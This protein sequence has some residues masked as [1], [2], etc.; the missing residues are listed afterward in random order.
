M[1]GNNSTGA[2][3]PRPEPAELVE[4][5]RRARLRAYC[6][7]SEFA[8]GAAVL[9]GPPWQVTTGCNIENAAYSETVC[10]ERVAVYNA[11]SAALRPIVAIAVVAA[12]VSPPRPC[13]ACLQ[14]LAELAPGADLYLATPDGSFEQMGL[15]ELLP[16][17]FHL[18][19]AG[20]RM[21]P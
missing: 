17:P 12:G 10:A 18:R 5:A 21:V 7:Y 8:V 14:V 19:G 15:A 16:H 4:A 13:G 1:T 2:S 3:Q 20:G 9:T 11:V 6:P